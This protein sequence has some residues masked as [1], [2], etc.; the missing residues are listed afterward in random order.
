MSNGNYP[1][2]PELRRLIMQRK[3]YHLLRERPG[4]AYRKMAYADA[5]RNRDLQYTNPVREVAYGRGAQG[6]VSE[7]LDVSRAE[8]RLR[9]LQGALR[10]R[11]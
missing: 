8:S 9:R 3:A 7:G 11:S 6:S 2:I 10:R 4:V 5:M 1:S